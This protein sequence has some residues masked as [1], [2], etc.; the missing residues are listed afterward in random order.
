ML[1]SPVFKK[2]E[3]N[4]RLEYK[5]IPWSNAASL[6]PRRSNNLTGNL[7][8][9]WLYIM[10]S[11][12]S[13][14]KEQYAPLREVAKPSCFGVVHSSCPL[15]ET[16]ENMRPKLPLRSRKRSSPSSSDKGT[17]SDGS[18]NDYTVEYRRSNRSMKRA[19]TDD[20][21]S[22]PRRQTRSMRSEN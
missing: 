10:A 12:S 2:V 6:D 19:R 21:D 11:V 5:A 18:D 20:E 8:L 4:G 7:A 1:S 16:S 13:N 14:I 3:E 22:Q 15:S 17:T 9:W